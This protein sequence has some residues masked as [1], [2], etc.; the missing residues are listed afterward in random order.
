MNSTAKVV[1]YQKDFRLEDVLVLI[2]ALGKTT[3]TTGQIGDETLRG[4]QNRLHP[5]SAESKSWIEIAKEHPEFFAF[6]A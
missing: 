6:P 3:N 5:Q 4:E 1:R 2:Q